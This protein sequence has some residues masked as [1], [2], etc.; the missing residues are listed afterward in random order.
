MK[1]SAT[2]F[3]FLLAAVFGCGSSSPNMFQDPTDGGGDSSDPFKGDSGLAY[4]D[5]GT[6]PPPSD[7]LTAIIRDF[8]LFKNGDATTN[9]DFENPPQM[10]TNLDDHGIA[11]TTLG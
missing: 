9:P 6:P 1:T 10:N 4:K 3:A 7:Q 2:P 5:T 8:K 11:Q